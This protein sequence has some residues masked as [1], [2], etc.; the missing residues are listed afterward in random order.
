MLRYLPNALTISRLVLALPLGLLIL[1]QEFALALGVGLLAGITDALDGYSARKLGYLS[2]LGAALDPVADKLLI[3]VS[4][5]CM[6]SVSL[7]DWS[8]AALVIGR[9]L[10]IVCG[11]LC[12]RLLVGPFTFGATTLSKL[13]MAIQIGFCVLILSAQLLPIPNS[14]VLLCSAAVVLA[15]IASG[16]DYVVTWSRLARQSG[17]ES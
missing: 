7:I 2:Q 10:V 8:L 15:A 12:Y 4:F 16:L 11:A 13:N 6:A 5:F 17:G 3:L 1:R 14:L 9:D